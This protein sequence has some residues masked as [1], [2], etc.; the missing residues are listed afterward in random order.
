MS[1]P[2]GGLSPRKLTSRAARSRRLRPADLASRLQHAASLDR[3]AGPLAGAAQRA[4]S[5]RGAADALHGVWL[6]QPLHP[7]LTGLPVGCWLSAALLDL[8]P[9]SQRA[10]RAL[11]ALGVA[12]AV[13]TAAAGLADW[14]ARHP[15]Q[16]RVGRAH[17]AAGAG[18]GSMFTASLAARLAGRHRAGRLLTLGGLAALTAG[19][20][21]GRYLAFPLGA[22]ASHA[23]PVT[24]LSPLGW[25]ELCR[26]RE[27]PEGRPVRRRLG[28]L[29]LFVLRQGPEV[30]VLADHCTHLGG[31]LHQGTL[32]ERDGGPCIICPWH[33]STFLV[34]DGSVVHG[35]AT[36]RQPGFEA[37]VSDQGVVEVRPRL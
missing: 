33:G 17:A 4:L 23:E 34:A 9:G 1:Q 16:Q 20:Y 27:L 28:Y 7:A 36:A 15:E 32:A 2:L 3:A 11:I 30:M 21:L 5:N 26:S 25:H 18:A 8:V 24:H 37:R 10:A 12:A 6:G 22:G 13:P 14:S 35:P 31:P 29:S 19:T